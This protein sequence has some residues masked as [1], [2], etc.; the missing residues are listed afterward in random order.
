ML[1]ASISN[2]HHPNVT[3]IPWHLSSGNSVAMNQMEQYAL[4]CIQPGLQYFTTQL[5]TSLR[6]PLAAFKAAR[7]LNPQKVA[8]MLPTTSDVNELSSFPFVTSMMLSDLKAEL[9]S[10]VAKAD[11]VDPSFCRLSWWKD[12]CTSL[13]HWSALACKILLVQS[14]FAAAERVFSLLTNSFCDKQTNALQ[15]Y[16]E[17]SIILQYTN[18]ELN[19]YIHTTHYCVMNLNFQWLFI[20]YNIQGITGKYLGI[21]GDFWRKFSKE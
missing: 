17:T 21:I 12:N 19:L 10:Y 1:Q 9:P 5:G 8:E 13:P 15:D 3:A 16:I 20:I 6:V 11:G 18:T 7:L 14:S 2:S 4:G